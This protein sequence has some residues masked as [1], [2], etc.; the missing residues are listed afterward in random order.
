VELEIHADRDPGLGPE[1]YPN[2]NLGLQIYLLQAQVQTLILGRYHRRKLIMKI[3]H[4]VLKNLLHNEEYTRS[5]LP[6]LKSEYFSDHNDRSIFK[7]INSFVTEYNKQASVE[8]IKIMTSESKKIKIEDSEV[9]SNLL[10][11][12]SKNEQTD[13]KFL[14]KQTESFCKEK[15]LHN[16]ILDSIKIISDEKDTRDKGSIPEILKEALAIT[17]DPSVGHDFVSDAETRFEFYHK[18]EERIRF[19]IQNLN[20]IT[21][22]GLPRKTLNLILGG[23]NAGK[24][25]AMC[26]MAASNVLDG[27]NVLYITCEM[28]EERIAERIDANLLD[29]TLDTLKQISKKQFLSLINK[30]ESR[31]PGK[32]VIKE[33]PTGSANVSHFRYLLHELAL[34]KKF[35]PDIIYIDYL[36]ICASSRIKNNGQVNSYMLVKSIA[37]EV[38]GLA[39]EA[40]LPI[41]SASQF[42]RSGASDSDAGMGDIAESF[43]VAATCDFMIALINTEE[44]E[45]LG[46]LMIKQLKNRY[47][48]VT[49]NKKFLV[50]IDRSKMRL[51]DIG[52]IQID[53]EG[54]IQD[55]Y[56]DNNYGEFDSGYGSSKYKKNFDNFKF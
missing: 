5:V 38:R 48:D 10:D 32:L 34:K 42:T 31:T 7:F 27:K 25:L 41:V 53:G 9:I 11:S 51:F 3:E 39:V 4:L 6:F 24:T 40:N 16:A 36:N 56:Q 13:L 8:A 52:D 33:Y 44:L 46:Q 15:S 14:I 20:L 26:H 45:K 37:E 47:N 21:G 1:R 28:A 43:G 18:K 23:V 22:G 2:Q 19:D 54:G 12:W 55:P 49:K 50:G 30:L 35:I 17:F 29:I